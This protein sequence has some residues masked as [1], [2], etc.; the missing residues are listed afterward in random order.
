MRQDVF[1]QLRETVA[2]A[3]DGPLP[4]Q[5]TAVFPA[6]HELVQK[7]AL[8]TDIASCSTMLA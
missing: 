2:K 7:D 8:I 3:L 6:Q 5:R 4:E 1:E